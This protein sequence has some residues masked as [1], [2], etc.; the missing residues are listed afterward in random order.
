MLN[1]VKKKTPLDWYKNM[2]LL[3]F[4]ILLIH[5]TGNNLRENLKLT[6]KFD[7]MNRNFSQITN[8]S[9]QN[10]DTMFIKTDKKGI[11]ETCHLIVRGFL[12]LNLFGA[13]FRVEFHFVPECA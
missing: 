13:F 12:V 10:K 9:K 11:G 7:K 4:L 2:I 8:I 6:V 3:K 1:N 5:N